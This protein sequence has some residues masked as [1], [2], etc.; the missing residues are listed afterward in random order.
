M[1]KCIKN[2]KHLYHTQKEANRIISYTKINKH[3]KT[4]NIKLYNCPYSYH[5]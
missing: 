3:V 4:H 1:Q 2:K 5:A